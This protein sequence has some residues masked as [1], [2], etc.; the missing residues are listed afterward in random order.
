MPGHTERHRCV[1]FPNLQGPEYLESR[2]NALA[3]YLNLARRGSRWSTPSI[4]MHNILVKTQGFLQPTFLTNKIFTTWAFEFALSS[5]SK[6]ETSYQHLSAIDRNLSSTGICRKWRFI[7]RDSLQKVRYVCYIA[8][9]HNWRILDIISQA[10]D[11]LLSFFVMHVACGW[12]FAT[13]RSAVKIDLPR[14]AL[15]RKE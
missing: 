8:G 1:L 5:S 11:P 2:K 4:T 3:T 10:I 13:S 15:P 12:P 9:G 14:L 6:A 7:Y